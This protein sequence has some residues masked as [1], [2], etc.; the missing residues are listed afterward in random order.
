MALLVWKTIHLR[1]PRMLAEI[2]E[3]IQGN[4][5]L[6]SGSDLN[7]AKTP[8]GIPTN[9]S[10]RRFAYASSTFNELPRRI[11]DIDDVSRFKRALKTYICTEAFASIT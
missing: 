8:K 1:Q 9:I 4:E 6:R 2:I 10:K 7:K 5:K 11:R 3:P